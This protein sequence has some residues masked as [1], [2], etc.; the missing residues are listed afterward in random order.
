MLDKIA[1]SASDLKSKL[2]S[3][4]RVVFTNGCFDILHV[5]HIDYLAKAREKGDCLIV[6]VN[7]DFSIKELKGPDRPINKLNDRLKMLSALSFVDHLISFDQATPLALIK[8]ILPDVLVKG[9]DYVLEEI[10]GYQEITKNGGKVETI[11]IK[12]H[13]S[14][15]EIIKKINSL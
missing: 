10:V 13:I 15:S 11:P 1:L 7:S 4:S 6:A 2:K 12:H 5:G 8:E 14:S 3:C 9:G